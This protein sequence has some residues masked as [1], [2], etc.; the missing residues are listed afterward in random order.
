MPSRKLNE[1]LDTGFSDDDPSSSH[2]S[3]NAQESKGRST[4]PNTGSKRQKTSHESSDEASDDEN[5]P[6]MK[7]SQPDNPDETSIP[8]KPIPTDKPTPKYPTSQKATE[9][10]VQ[11]STNTSPLRP[12]PKPG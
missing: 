8:S 10:K 7:D 5:D 1:Y 11:S 6:V 9:T 4:I 3:D 12:S 2:D